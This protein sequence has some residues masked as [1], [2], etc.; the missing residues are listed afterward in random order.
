MPSAS[1]RHGFVATAKSFL[2]EAHPHGRYPTTVAPQ[3]GHPAFYLRRVGRTAGVFFPF[4]AIALGWPVLAYGYY[5]KFP[6][7]F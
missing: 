5:K 6:Y 1:P 7:E 4:Y 2:S 3:R